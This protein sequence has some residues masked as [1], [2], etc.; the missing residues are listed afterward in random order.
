[1]FTVFLQKQQA[2]HLEE[3]RRR[4]REWEVRDRVLGER[5][6]KVKEEEE[7]GERRRQELQEEREL[8][9]RNREQHHRDLDR[10]REA[11]HRLER[12]KEALRRDT[13]RLEAQ[14]REQVSG[15]VLNVWI[16]LCGTITTVPETNP[17]SSE[18]QRIILQ[19]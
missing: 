19:N 14:H 4:E 2:A 15:T 1:M 3:K 8:L 16:C 6:E 13:E 12:D 18:S 11:Q 9:Q 7:R 10:L 17:N 5:E